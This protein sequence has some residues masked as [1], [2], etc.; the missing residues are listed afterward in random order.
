MIYN[1]ML[2][3][4]KE[5]I[6]GKED[7]I[8]R[9]IE[10]INEGSC[11]ATDKCGMVYNSVQLDTGEKFDSWLIGAYYCMNRSFELETFTTFFDN[12]CKVNF[13]QAYH[14]FEYWLD[15]VVIDNLFEPHTKYKHSHKHNSIHRDLKSNVNTDNLTKEELDQLEFL[16]HVAVNCVKHNETYMAKFYFELLEKLKFKKIKQIK[17]VGTGT[18]PKEMVDYKDELVKFKAND[19]F[20]TIKIKIMEDTEPAYEKVLI[21]L[22]NLLESSFPK[23]YSITFSTSNKELLPIKKLV[24]C[25][26]HSLFAGAI[27]YPNLHSNILKY[28]NLV[29]NKGEYYTNLMDKEGAVLPSTFAVFALVLE[30]EKYIDILGNYLNNVDDDHQEIQQ[31][32]TPAFIEKYGFNKNTVKV[33][34]DLILS[35]QNH[36]YNKKMLSYF[37]SDEGLGLL[38]DCKKNFK[39]YY[40]PE[41][42]EP[43]DKKWNHVMKVTFGDEDNFNKLR[44]KMTQNQK[45]I[46]DELTKTY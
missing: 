29:M 19:V 9:F 5:R 15:D 46:F 2:Q 35:M 32:L 36:P 44:K 12:F 45:E 8:E 39:E 20:A 28:I 41:H 37:V 3:I 21:L 14:G 31:F 26:A 24:K 18:L 6:K 13:Q 43:V 4:A 1:E 30:D 25:G 38:L 42:F 7:I 40:S 23:S 11:R 34:I 22:S 27:K 33:Y 10:A 17:K 16:C